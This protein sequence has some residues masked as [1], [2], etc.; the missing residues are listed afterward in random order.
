M[1]NIYKTISLLLVCLLLSNLANSQTKSINLILAESEDLRF[2]DL[3]AVSINNHLIFE[4]NINSVKSIWSY[5]TDTKKLIS[6]NVSGATTLT[7]FRGN[8]VIL[9]NTDEIDSVI[10]SDGTLSGT[11][12]LLNGSELILHTTQYALYL[13]S[14]GFQSSTVYRYDGQE[15][16]R[17]DLRGDLVYNFRSNKYICEPD[18]EKFSVLLNTRNFQGGVNGTVLSGNYTN[19]D[20][21]SLPYFYTPPTDDF[22]TVLK[23]DNLLGQCF[24]TVIFGPS[25]SGY[26]PILQYVHRP[27]SSNS[28]SYYDNE[29]VKNLS[30]FTELGSQ[31]YA[32][33]TFDVESFFK[34]HQL[35]PETLES[36][37]AVQV[38]LPEGLTT[39]IYSPPT[40]VSTGDALLISYVDL[41]LFDAELNPLSL[42]QSIFSSPLYIERE[43]DVYQTPEFTLLAKKYLLPS[44]Y[45]YDK[46]SP[47]ITYFSNQRFSARFKSTQQ[48]RLDQIHTNPTDQVVNLTAYDYNTQKLGYYQ[49]S[50]Q[51]KISQQINGIWYNDALNNQGLSISKGIRQDRSEYVFLTAYLFRDGQPLWLAGNTN[52]NDS[53]DTL[54][55]D[56]Y[57]YDGPQLFEPNQTANRNFFGRIELELMSCNTLQA[58]I[59]ADDQIHQLLL[60]RADN[61]FYKG[62]CQE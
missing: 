48:V 31:L 21:P 35:N 43:T 44:F 57:E 32:I 24:F 14:P 46:Q 58:S 56:L 7:S 30:G 26:P 17:H 9:K 62:W 6:L 12:V 59:E 61:T 42:D 16:T 29:F 13:L 28:T 47:E 4:R 2:G 20:H 23:V 45:G 11:T 36:I 1:K 27:D 53:P 39:S 41:L 37:A 55:I 33:E 19:N 54:T 34:L 8:A 15:L 10:I 38:D 3:G 22:G 52:L 5:D 49:I 25:Y 18:S 60:N 40:L 51:P 50:D